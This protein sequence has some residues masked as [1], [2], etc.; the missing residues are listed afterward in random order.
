MKIDRFVTLYTLLCRKEG[1]KYC[2][3]KHFWTNIFLGDTR[4]NSVDFMVFLQGHLN[5]SSKKQK[6]NV[7]KNRN[8]IAEHYTKI[9]LLTRIFFQ[10]A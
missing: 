9:L 1:S 4:E 10:N 8:L 7:E 5:D 2:G 6:K 3:K